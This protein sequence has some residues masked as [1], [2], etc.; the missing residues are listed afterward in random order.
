MS[1]YS[2]HSQIHRFM[3]DTSWISLHQALLRRQPPLGRSTGE[4]YS[5]EVRNMGAPRP[6][7]EVDVNLSPSREKPVCGYS[8]PSPL[9]SVSFQN[10]MFNSYEIP[11]PCQANIALVVSLIDLVQVR[12]VDGSQP[13]WR[14]GAVFLSLYLPTRL[15]LRFQ[16]IVLN[17]SRAFLSL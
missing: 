16:S 14:S 10:N 7:Q 1:I 3:N 9:Y 5:R 15:A 6:L 12:E 13:M 11:Y 17:P 2:P 4:K 8:F